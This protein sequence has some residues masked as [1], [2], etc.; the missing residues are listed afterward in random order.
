MN[1]RPR[2][3][4]VRLRSVNPTERA[5][6]LLGFVS[7]VVDGQLCIDGVTVRRTRRG[8]AV[9]SFPFRRDRQGNE[10]PLVRPVN[11]CARREI[12]RQVFRA[13][14]INQGSAP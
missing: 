8:Q 3:S 9:L 5:S 10:H 14:G 7:F 13:L 11:D 12:E 6:G 4:E 1:D 2:I